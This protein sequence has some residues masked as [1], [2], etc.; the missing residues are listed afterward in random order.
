MIEIGKNTKYLNFK[1]FK[2][3]NIEDLINYS[4]LNM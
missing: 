2:S 4:S 3:L 1:S